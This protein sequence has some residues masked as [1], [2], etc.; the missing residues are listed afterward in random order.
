MTSLQMRQQLVPGRPRLGRRFSVPHRI[1]LVGP[2]RDGCRGPWLVVI[3]DDAH[4][5][6]VYSCVGFTGAVVVHV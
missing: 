1:R 4:L 2:L 5:G 6:G 3:L